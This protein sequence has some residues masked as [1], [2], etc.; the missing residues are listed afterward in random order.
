MA[1]I[2]KK[3][4]KANIRGSDKIALLTPKCKAVIATASRNLIPRDHPFL[5]GHLWIQH[6]VTPHRYIAG[7]VTSSTVLSEMQKLVS[8]PIIQR[9]S[10]GS[11][12][13]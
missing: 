12:K 6:K 5:C 9:S 13:L 1:K 11:W 7:S 4:T 2:Q 10:H 8:A 3:L